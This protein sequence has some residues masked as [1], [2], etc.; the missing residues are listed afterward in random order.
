MSIYIS[1]YESDVELFRVVHLFVAG[2]VMF[3]YLILFIRSSYYLKKPPPF[4]V[5]DF[6]RPCYSVLI[7]VV[8]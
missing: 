2:T 6:V 4:S 8:K 7:I 3:T 5:G 1:E